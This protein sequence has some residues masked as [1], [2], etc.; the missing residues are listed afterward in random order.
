MEACATKGFKRVLLEL[1]GG[2]CL[3]IINEQFLLLLSISH[4]L[5]LF[6]EQLFTAYI[7]LRLLFVVIY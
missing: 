3:F 5:Y 6:F 4:L 7:L 1:G 2:L